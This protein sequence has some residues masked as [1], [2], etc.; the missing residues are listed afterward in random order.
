[1]PNFYIAVSGLDA[2]SQALNTI[3]NNL[4]N[5][6]TVAYKAKTANFSD[7]FYESLGQNNAGNQL[8][9]GTGAKVASTST[10][11]TQGDYNTS[12]MSSTDVAVD[13]NG[14]FVVNDGSENFL[15]RDGQLSA[16]TSGH[17]ETASGDTLM[18]YQATDGVVS[19]TT[20]SAIT[21]PTAGQVMSP[22]ASTNFTI[23]ANLDSAAAT[24]STYTST[25]PLYDSLGTAV[26]ATVTY[27]NNGNNTWGYSVA[28][29]A[30]SFTSG[31]STPITGTLTFDA[32]GN[33]ASVTSGGVTSTVGTATGD[34]STIPIAFTGL[35]D[36]ATDLSTKWNLLN[37]N[38]A[39]ILTQV[40]SDSVTSSSVAN[41]YNA[42]TYNGFSVNSDGSVEASYSN[43]QT[44]LVGQVALADVT[45]EQGLTTLGNGLYKTTLASGTANIGIAG[46]G[47]LGTIKDDALE[48]SNVDISGEF[49]QLIIAQRAFEA[50]SK[51]IT[52]FDTVT[53]DI[54]GIIR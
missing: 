10:D 41:G 26:N 23:E 24:N 46:T 14:F 37:T 49:S 1:M 4:S 51:S 47:A 7:M 54:I 42:G 20:L 33:L 38:G 53:Q 11:F 39:Q 15:T 48:Q 3:A 17:L 34:V 43:G 45:N 30:A 19:A 36:G 9:V 8:Q 31:V 16:D 28:L 12:G 35:A 2:D 50:N 25:V 22:V 13:G 32:S 44:Q 40:D 18:G 27:T 5:M 21:L 29:P 6:S 52:T